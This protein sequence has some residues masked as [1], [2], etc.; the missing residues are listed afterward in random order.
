MAG[1]GALDV[2]ALRLVGRRGGEA[3]V[4]KVDLGQRLG[5][6]VET[7]SQRA[8]L[9][10][11]ARALEVVQQE[12]LLPLESLELLVAVQHHLA[13]PL[14]FTVA[15]RTTHESEPMMVMSEKAMAMMKMKV[16]VGGRTRR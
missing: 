5:A 7:G 6:G 10:L 4:V 12:L 8:A 2:A 1:V 16:V 9:L 14:L 13:Q 15:P 11:L 3:V